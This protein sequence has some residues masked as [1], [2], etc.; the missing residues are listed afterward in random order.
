[1]YPDSNLPSLH[2]QPLIGSDLHIWTAALSGS[3]EQLAYFDSLLTVD[4]KVRAQRFYFERDRNRYIFAR[5]TLRTLLAVYLGLEP[6]K[7]P[8]IYGPIGK[9]AL[10]PVPGDK[11]LE[12]NVAH[13]N[14]W[15]A[16][17]FGWE[18]PLGIDLEHV[19]PLADVD[20]LAQRFFCARESEL[21]HSLSG[22]EKW[23]TF[24]KIWTCKEA[25]LKAHGSGLTVPLNH[26]EI[27]MGLDDVVRISSI[28]EEAAHLADW[29]LELI[30]L[31]P[32]YKSAFAVRGK[33][34]KLVFQKFAS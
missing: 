28:A 29:H 1:M 15:A 23:E 17:V 12:F 16:Y 4:E 22:D 26:F 10:G 7:I 18:R 6:P 9:P 32:G 27:S 13:S 21:I 34:D 14:D 2:I 11:H 20:A 25:I 30:D 19:R 31:V 33:T 8:I 24:F 3:V 5:G